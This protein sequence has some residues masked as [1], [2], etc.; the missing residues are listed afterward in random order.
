MVLC[1]GIG[2][3]YA[4]T[5]QING[6]VTSKDDGA[7][8]PGV[9]VA[10]EGTTSGTITDLDGNFSL[11]VPEG[12][13]LVISFIGMKTVE[14]PVTSETIYNV[15][16]ETESIGVEEVV[17]TAMGIRRDKKALGY[18]VSE[19]TSE[20]FGN[21]GPTEVVA[22]PMIDAVNETANV[23]KFIKASGSETWWNSFQK[24]A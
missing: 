1:I 22:N 23:A 17:V 19:F 20:D 15:V 8:I 10:V 13:R 24:H 2:T 14:V 16:L 21:V 5:K 3:I 12:S 4:Q 6:K 9:S 7:P 18:C 11:I